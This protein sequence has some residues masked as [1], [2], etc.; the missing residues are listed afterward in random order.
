MASKHILPFEMP[1]LAD[2]QPEQ[3]AKVRGDLGVTQQ[4]MA[5]FSEML[6]D[7]KPGLEHPEVCHVFSKLIQFAFEGSVNVWGSPCHLSSYAES[8]GGADRPGVF[9]WH[10]SFWPFLLISQVED[11][12][13]TADLLE[14]NDDMNNLFLRWDLVANNCSSHHP[15]TQVWSVWEEQKSEPGKTRGNQEV[16]SLGSGEKGSLSPLELSRMLLKPNLTVACWPNVTEAPLIDFSTPQVKIKQ[17]KI[18]SSIWCCIQTLGAT[19]E[20]A[21]LA[22]SLANFKVEGKFEPP[23]QNEYDCVRMTMQRTWPIG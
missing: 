20:P 6:S 5:V 2:M 23:A 12:K 9:C 8:P 18:V 4:N 21:S 10:L 13:L 19:S 7:L 16:S 22:P 11:D 3:V 14:V 15:P 1:P 17:P